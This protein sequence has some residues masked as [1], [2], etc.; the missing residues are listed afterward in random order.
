MAINSILV[1]NIMSFL[2][3]SLASK[4]KCVL[5]KGIHVWF[6]QTVSIHPSLD[7]AVHFW[8]LQASFKDPVGLPENIISQ[9]P[10]VD[11]HVIFPLASPGRLPWGFYLYTVAHVW[12]DVGEIAY[13][14]G[15]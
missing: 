13:D 2:A 10:M 12:I 4:P 15:E 3:S 11:H 5:L 1:V 6:S 7:Q 14:F 8:L 9:T